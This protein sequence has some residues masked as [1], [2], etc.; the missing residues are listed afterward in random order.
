MAAATSTPPA[1]GP[2]SSPYTTYTHQ[3]LVIHSHVFYTLQRGKRVYSPC[4]PSASEKSA[5][6]WFEFEADLYPPLML[7]PQTWKRYN[8][9]VEDVHNTYDKLDA[10]YVWQLA[11]MLLCGLYEPEAASAGV[12]STFQSLFT[13]LFISRKAVFDVFIENQTASISKRVGSSLCY[14]RPDHKPLLPR[15]TVSAELFGTC[16]SMVPPVRPSF[17]RL[18]RYD[19]WVP[20]KDILMVPVEFDATHQLVYMVRVVPQC[21]YDSMPCKPRLCVVTMPVLVVTHSQPDERYVLL[22]EACFFVC[23]TPGDTGEAQTDA[24]V[25]SA[26]KKRKPL[27]KKTSADIKKRKS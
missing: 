20:F 5:D 21:V 13:F 12:R 2:Q 1:A 25:T 15:V 6:A 3:N 14:E 22:D 7:M 10:S 26:V 19:H 18:T 16:C 23:H 17:R 8:Y 9:T 4:E 24:T 11:L 27:A